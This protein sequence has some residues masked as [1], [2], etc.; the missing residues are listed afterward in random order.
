MLRRT[1][2]ALAG[3]PVLFA[4]V[5]W[6][7]PGLT[8]LL[9]LI[10]GLGLR[11]FYRLLP[12]GP[13]ILPIALGTLWAISLILGGQAASGLSSFLII[14]SIILA[15]GAFVGMLWLVAFYPEDRP[16][17]AALYLWG[18]PIFVGFFLA[19][20]LA[21]LEIG[22]TSDVGR[23]WLLLTLFTV[24][25]TD[26]GAFLVGRSIGKHPMA[27]VVSPNK[28]WEGAIG[29]MAMALVAVVVLGLIFDVAAPRWQQIVIGATVGVVSQLGDLF[30]SKLKRLS[31]AKDAGSMIPGHGGV[32][33]R[34]DSVAVTIPVVYYIL[35]TVFE[36]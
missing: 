5:W 13:D 33:D 19:H 4:A 1:L 15:A 31:N 10:A 27:P 22:A 8:V 34:L 6:G 36:L 18:G 3:I 26:T 23:D 17:I 32:L 7:A 25:A 28:T 16:H 24:F 20:S 29:G 12:Q 30:E 14:S 21:L 11:E 35:A 9:L 2:T